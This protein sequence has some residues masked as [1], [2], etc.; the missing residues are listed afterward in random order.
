MSSSLSVLFSVARVLN[1]RALLCAMVF[2]ACTPSHAKS[3]A[4]VCETTP[5]E[6]VASVV[7]QSGG[8]RASTSVWNLVVESNQDGAIT[9]V[10]V[11]AQEKD[12]ESKSGLLSFRVGLITTLE[13]SLRSGKARTTYTGVDTKERG[14]CSVLYKTNA[15]SAVDL[16]AP[17]QGLSDEQLCVQGQY[18]RF[19]MFEPTQIELA[20]RQLN[21][22]PVLKHDGAAR[23]SARIDAVDES[24]GI[25]LRKLKELKSFF[26]QNLITKEE[27]DRKKASL[28]DAM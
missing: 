9:K 1:M 15:P 14:A 20:R 18:T 23:V 17:I 27:Y 7:A 21:C 8:A 26:E 3:V 13:L 10:S 11:G 16:I 4:L 24:A 22:E 19:M 28:L 2:I 25:T 5:I 12:F 6:E